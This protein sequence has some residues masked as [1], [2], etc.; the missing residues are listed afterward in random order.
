MT[1][2]LTNNMMIDDAAVTD[3]ITLC[4]TD[5]FGPSSQIL[6][7]LLSPNVSLGCSKMS[8]YVDVGGAMS[9]GLLGRGLPLLLQ[10]LGQCY[11]GKGKLHPAPLHVSSSTDH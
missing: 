4:T 3:L 2:I 11:G 1:M 8:L 9:A 5:W 10:A 6:T 7:R